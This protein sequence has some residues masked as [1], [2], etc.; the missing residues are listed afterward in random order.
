MQHEQARRAHHLDRVARRERVVHP[1]RHPPAGH[2]LHRRGERIADVGRARHRVAA[3][4]RLAVDR[5]RGTCRT[6]RPRRRTSSASAGGTSR[7]ND[8][9]S[10]VSSTTATTGERVVL[11]VGQASAIPVGGSADDNAISRF[12]LVWFSVRE[13][14]RVVTRQP[15]THA[16]G[17]CGRCRPRSASAT[18]P[19]GGGPTRRSAA[20]VDRSLRARARRRP[21][22]SGRRRGRGTAPTPTSTPTRCGS[23][24]R[25]R[26]AGLEPGDV[27][28]FQLPNWREAVVA[29]YGLAMGGYVLVPIVHIYGPKE[30]RF[31]LGQSGARAYI[32]ADRY[33]HV[34]YLDIVDGAAPDELAGSGAA[35]RR[36]RRPTARRR[37]R[38]CGASAGTSSTPRRRPR[39][40]RRRRP[41]RRVRAR[42]HVGHDERSRRA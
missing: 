23:S 8:R 35:R 20:L 40:D 21:C 34:D 12:L 16:R 29:F 17:R 31:I 19:R 15:M 33:G 1:V 37:A 24:P 10:A 42:V 41:R 25:S 5:R 18:S 7:T 6:A 2:P 27:V 22:T 28:A 3:D 11:V 14:R 39:R 38:A 30:V 26:D 32:S 13:W 9:V 36:R 4:D